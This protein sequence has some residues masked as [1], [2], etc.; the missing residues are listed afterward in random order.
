V[1]IEETVGAIGELIDAGYVRYVGLSEMGLKPDDLA[2]I[3]AAVPAGAV[4][5]DRYD[6]Q[7][8]TAL[9]SER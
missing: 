6:E 3:E 5:G 1:P 4:A 8:M 7:Q 9:D 2:A